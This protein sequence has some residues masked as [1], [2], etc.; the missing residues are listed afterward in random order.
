[1]A[2]PTDAATPTR[3]A[4]D[5]PAHR[6]GESDRRF[7]VAA[8]IGCVALIGF[9]A[10]AVTQASTHKPVQQ[11]MFPTAHPTLMPAGRIA[12][13]FSLAR[14]GGGPPVVLHA[15]LSKP[16]VMNFFASWCANCRA[17]LSTLAA[18]ARKERGKVQFVGIDASDT[19][20]TL[21]E[22]LLATARASY[23]VGVDRPGSITNS[24]LVS[25]LPVTM[26]IDT[27]GRVVGELYGAQ[28]TVS[29]ERGIRGLLA[30]P[31]PR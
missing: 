18:V 17:E 2:D 26:F 3:A 8:L 25:D 30:I 9:V 12:P 4:L 19:D 27:Q 1:M 31:V 11:A 16:V 7:K 10:F 13:A 24:Y 15:L 6:R 5:T 23:P 28:T 20:P 21:A 14:L 22:S 29:L